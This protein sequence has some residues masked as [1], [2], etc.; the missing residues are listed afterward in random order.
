MRSFWSLV[1]DG[2]VLVLGKRSWLR[3]LTITHGAPIRRIR[4][5]LLCVVLVASVVTF[6]HEEHNYF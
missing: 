6:L 5:R 2:A 1:Y 4:V 3:L